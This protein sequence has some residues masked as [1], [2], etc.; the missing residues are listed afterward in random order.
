MIASMSAGVITGVVIVVVVVVVLV[1]VV[2][3]KALKVVQ[4][5]SVGVVKR[6]GE[7]KSVRQPGIAFLV[8]FFDQ[9]EKVDIREFPHT[10]D[11]QSVITADNVSLQVERHDLRPGT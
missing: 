1:A 2:L 4:Q 10:G 3:K 7:F 5:G 9:M 8:P 6:L 11:R